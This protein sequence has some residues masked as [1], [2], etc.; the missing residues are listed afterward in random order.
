MRWINVK[1]SENKPGLPFFEIL[2][3]SIAKATG[4]VTDD[5]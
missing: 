2:E 3:S 5:L 4:T 1:F